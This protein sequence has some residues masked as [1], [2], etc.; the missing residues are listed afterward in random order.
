VIDSTASMRSRDEDAGSRLD[1]AK[2]LAREM[3]DSLAGADRAAIIESSSRVTVRSPLTSDHAA[4][5]SAIN[6]IQETDAPG[7]LSDAIR[8]AEQIS[9]SESDSSVVIISD[10]GSVI[11]P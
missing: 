8:L 5:A 6:D 1:R 9:K 2:Q 10:G 11:S 7:S 3:I 4:L